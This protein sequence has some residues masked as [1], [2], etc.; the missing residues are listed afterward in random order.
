MKTANYID[1]AR[2]LTQTGSDYAVAKLLG[3]TENAVNHYRLGRRVMDNDT[4][5]RLAE[6]LGRPLEELIAVA[7]M[8]RAK[9][10]PTRKA[11]EKRLKT[12]GR[13]AAAV[14]IAPALIIAAWGHSATAD[15]ALTSASGPGNSWAL[16]SRTRSDTSTNYTTWQIGS[17]N[18][19]TRRCVT[20][21]GC[22]KYSRSSA[23]P[24]YG[25]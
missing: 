11:W 10:E 23:R 18:G 20:R 2:K 13:R 12:V 21:A 19:P 9:D 1:M 4:C 15:G 6:A 17:E 25:A 16:E 22:A 7:E 8:E 3:I 24:S 5:R 14:L